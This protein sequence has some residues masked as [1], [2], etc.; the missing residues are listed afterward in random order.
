MRRLLPA[1][2][3]VA[4]CATACGSHHETSRGKPLLVVVNAPFSKTP[5]L[6]RTI[7]NGVRLAVTQVD[8]SGL[9]VGGE[10]YH[11]RVRTMDDALSPARAVAN[12]RKAVADG[13]VAIVDD[14]TGVDASWRVAATRG[15]PI[16][17][18]FD[19]G[20]SLVDPATRPNVFR[21]APTDHGIAFRLAE[22]LVPK[23]LRI[24]I[25]HDDS[26]Y[27]QNGWDELR[28]AF[29]ADPRSVVSEQ[30]VPADALDLAPQILRARRA[31]ATALL[32]WGRPATIAAAITAARTARW[33]V[34]FFTPPTG[35][36]PFVRQQLADHPAWVDGLTFAAGRLTAEVGPR[37]FESFAQQYEHSFG[38]DKVGVKTRAGAEVTQPPETAMYAYDF[39][40]LLAAA[41]RSAASTDPGKVRQALEQV[42][43]EGANGDDRSFNHVSHE[44]VVDDDIYFAR[45]HDMTYAPVKDDP[46]SATLPTLA[47]TR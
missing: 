19:G 30:T 1:L 24:A 40:N 23:G 2:A 25:L 32:V 21:I 14:G 7:A 13:A 16:C 47:Q 22:Y 4:V 15:V 9:R 34:P 39:T 35:A 6:G 42:T 45:F 29:S 44:G 36:D 41:L 28:K 46:L 33:Q 20:S 11:L 38:V 18:V 27:G 37:P 5:Y 10:Q 12:V 8:A 26:D 31:R 17:I 43:V 3:L